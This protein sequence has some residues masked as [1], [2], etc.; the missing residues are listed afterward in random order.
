MY[1]DILVLL[2]TLTTFSPISEN[3]ALVSI[4]VSAPNTTQSDTTDAPLLGLASSNQIV[5]ASAAASAVSTAEIQVRIW[6]HA[7]IVLQRLSYQYPHLIKWLYETDLSTVY[8][9]PHED[10]KD[11]ADNN[12]IDWYSM[13]RCSHDDAIDI[14]L[15]NPDKIVIGGL[16]YN[17]NPRIGPLLDLKANDI[18]MAQNPQFLWSELCRSHNPA[19]MA[20]LAKPEHI[21]EINW[22]ILSRNECDEAAALLEA[23]YDRIHWRSLS[24][25]RSNGALVIL[26]NNRFRIV[27]NLFDFSNPNPIA[28]ELIELYIV[29]EENMGT[30]NIN[31]HPGLLENINAIEIISRYIEVLSN[32]SWAFLSN[33][34]NAIG[35]LSEHVESIDWSCLSS[36]SNAM[37]LL[38]Q[39]PQLICSSNLVRNT[40]P[41]AIA[42]LE[43][44]ILNS[45][46][47][48]TEISGEFLFQNPSALPLIERILKSGTIVSDIDGN[49]GNLK[50]LNT[51]F[52]VSTLGT[53][54]DIFKAVTYQKLSK[55]RMDILRDEFHN[56]ALRPTNI[57]THQD[58]ILRARGIRESQLEMQRARLFA[59]IRRITYISE[60]ED[61]M[62]ETQVVEM[63]EV[64]V[65]ED[66]EIFMSLTRQ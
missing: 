30:F 4:A 14:L 49:S 10:I 36:N 24:T 32:D 7:D 25:N 46:I 18:Y 45:N 17:Q 61:Q 34:K 9:N 19:V 44:L 29:Q 5:A 53:N 6:T 2:E 51:V 48:F 11:F 35:I 57:I 40:N 63:H 56:T 66:N 38:M 23:N 52:N 62:V 28:I 47:K 39:H 26:R 54:A 1:S 42:H 13:S 43:T 3:Q 50:M 58:A 33:N 64:T 16:V 27:W 55:I 20:F 12:Q 65:E 41:L 15:Q 21:E 59:V 31:D 60:E 8:I 37:E 22:I